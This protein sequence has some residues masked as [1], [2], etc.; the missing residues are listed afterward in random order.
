MNYH[1]RQAPP[2]YMHKKA[3]PQKGGVQQAQQKT[4]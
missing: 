3:P 1:P 4:T 2:M